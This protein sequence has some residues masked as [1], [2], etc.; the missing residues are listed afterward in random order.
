MEYAMFPDIPLRAVQ[1]GNA[2]VNK[3]TV[4]RAQRVIFSHIFQ[5]AVSFICVNDKKGLIIL[6]VCEKTL[7]ASE[8]AEGLHI[9]KV[10]QGKIRNRRT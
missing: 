5:N 9:E 10:F 3:E 2:A 8:D 4:A 7:R 6:S 1:M